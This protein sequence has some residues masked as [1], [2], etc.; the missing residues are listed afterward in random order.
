MVGYAGRYEWEREVDP[1]INDVGIEKFSKLTGIREEILKNTVNVNY[2]NFEQV[3]GTAFEYIYSNEI[4]SDK[5]TR[6]ELKELNENTIKVGQK[7]TYNKE[8]GLLE[9][10]NSKIH[11]YYSIQKSYGTN[12]IPQFCNQYYAK[13]GHK[14]VVVMCANGGEPI[15]NFLPSNDKDYG[16]RNETKK[17]YIYEAMVEKYSEAIKYLE[18]NGY[19]IGERLYV[20]S[21]TQPAINFVSDLSKKTIKDKYEAVFLK[22]HNRLKTDLGITKGAIVLN[23]S[24]PEEREVNIYERLKDVHDAQVNLTRRNDIILGS[25]FHWDNYLPRKEIYEDD[26]YKTTKFVNSKGE[27]ISY[28]AALKIAKYSLCAIYDTYKSGENKGRQYEDNSSHFTA[29][30]LSQTGYEVANSLAAVIIPKNN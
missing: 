1:R 12:M 3:S 14:V 30:A 15:S 24:R 27:K 2:T 22:V 23:G 13:T 18:N 11:S 28:D 8:T 9:K 26:S 16:E 25:S 29:A 6:G 19:G 5:K 7:L 20:V 4:N 10:Y 21:Q 17:Q